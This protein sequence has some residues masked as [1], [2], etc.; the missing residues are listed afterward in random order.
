MSHL[1]RTVNGKVPF[2]IF[3]QKLPLTHKLAL[4][5]ELNDS[6]HLTDSRKLFLKMVPFVNIS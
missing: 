6:V 1:P 3:L 4:S 2:K 5:D